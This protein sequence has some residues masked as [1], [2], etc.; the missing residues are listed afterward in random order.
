LDSEEAKLQERLP[1][2]KALI[3]HSNFGKL[4]LLPVGT[5]LSVLY[6]RLPLVGTVPVVL[7]ARN[8]GP[9]ENTV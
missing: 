1:D 5:D 3:D 2:L 8:Y 7:T 9:R 4:N 6:S